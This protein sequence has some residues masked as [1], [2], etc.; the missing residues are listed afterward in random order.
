M[1]KS[2]T[3]RAI[4]LYSIVRYSLGQFYN[5]VKSDNIIFDLRLSGTC[6]YDNEMGPSLFQS[7]KKNDNCSIESYL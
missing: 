6:P 5:H 4:F 2:I 3:V 7:K 1:L